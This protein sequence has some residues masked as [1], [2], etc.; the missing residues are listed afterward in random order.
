MIKDSGKIKPL[1]KNDIFVHYYKYFA[2]TE[3]E[4]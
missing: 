3:A 1:S 4:K 2:G